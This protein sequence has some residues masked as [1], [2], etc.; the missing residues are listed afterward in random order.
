MKYIIGF[1]I[2]SSLSGC[3]IPALLGV[4]SYDSNKDHTHIE[5]ITGF[6]GEASMSGTDTLNNNKGIKP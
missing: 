5:F 1:I 2:V 6:T 3:A 4:K